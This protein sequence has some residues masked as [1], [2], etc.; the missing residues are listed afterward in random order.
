MYTLQVN[1]TEVYI[2]LPV[3]TIKLVR[4]TLLSC[5][6]PLSPLSCPSAYLPFR[7]TNYNAVDDYDSVVIGTT[8]HGEL[9]EVRAGGGG[10]RQYGI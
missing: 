4:L 8:R 2:G 3:C 5:P 7:M 9:V 1:H 6:L 10:E